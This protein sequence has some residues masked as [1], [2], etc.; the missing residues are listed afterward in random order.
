MPPAPQFAGDKAFIGLNSRDNPIALPAGFVSRSENMRIDR[1]TLTVRKGLERLTDGGLINQTV[2]GSGVY[3]NGSGQETIVVCLTSSLYTFNPDTNVLVG[4]INYPSGQTITDPDVVTVFQAMDKVYI[5]R[6][7]GSR[8]FEFNYTSGSVIA[9]PTSG[10]QFPNAVYGIYY[11]NRII[12]QDSVDSVAVSHYLEATSFN[13][14]DIFKINDGGNDR[15]V[16]VCA[17]TLNEFVVMMRNSIFYVSVGSGSYDTGDNIAA[18]AYVKSLATDVGCAA[19]RSVVQAGGSILFLSDNGVYALN[20]QAAGAGT[21]N[22]PEGMRLLTV[23]EPLSAPIDDVIQRINRTYAHRSAGIY[24]N[25][26]YYLAV[27]L[28]A[29][30]KNSHILVYN[31]INKAWESIDSFPSGFDVQN[32]V[33]AKKGSQRRLFALDD[34]QGLFLMEELDADE[35]GQATGTPL[36]PFYLPETLSAASFRE[37]L[38]AGSCETRTYIFDIMESKRYASLEYDLAIPSGSAI[39]A[40]AVTLNP[41]KVRVLDEY[42]ADADGQDATRRVPIRMTAYGIRIR[43]ENL[44]KRPTIRGVLVDAIVPGRNT[45]SSD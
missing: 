13:Q 31:F 37:N 3:I 43:F 10:H 20:P 18:D 17:W 7:F 25:N 29:N 23:A 38:I 35:Y 5:T 19:K 12:V 8:P 4:P 26:R 14:T 11:G 1:G 22:T 40:S 9:L 28:D 16:S 39:R 32:F 44:S 41:D 42:G 36:L 15:L 6:G 21:T 33:V 45:K 27:P 2:Y 34:T 30:T 24:W